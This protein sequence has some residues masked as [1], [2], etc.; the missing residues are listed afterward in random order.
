MIRKLIATVLLAAQLPVTAIAGTACDAFLSEADKQE[1]FYS[2]AEATCFVG[3]S[4][5]QVLEA[6]HH[7]VGTTQHEEL[8]YL[9]VYESKNGKFGAIVVSDELAAFLDQQNEV[10]P[11][12]VTVVAADL[13]ILTAW[14][15]ADMYAQ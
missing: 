4:A 11:F 1:Y 13:A 2:E 7:Y 5:A 12:I 3:E 6:D 9:A 14:M 15:L 10:V 8:G